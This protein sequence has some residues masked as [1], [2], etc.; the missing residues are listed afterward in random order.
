MLCDNSCD[1]DLMPQE[2]MPIVNLAKISLGVALRFG[3]I[4]QFEAGCDHR[5]LIFIR[6]LIIEGMS[7]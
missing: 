3:V 2:P 4:D 7:E 5:Q 1:T 6:K